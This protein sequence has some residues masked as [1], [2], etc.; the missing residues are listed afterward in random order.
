MIRSADVLLLLTPRGM[1]RYIPA[2]LFDYLAADRPILVHGAKGEASDIVTQL[3]AGLFVPQGD[4]AAMSRALHEIRE[5]P[6]QR[7]QTA[8]RG[9]WMRDH[10]RQALAREFFRKLDGLVQRC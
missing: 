3:G 9:A 8:P 7:W 6:G 10:T 5:G 1:E 4:P 2:K